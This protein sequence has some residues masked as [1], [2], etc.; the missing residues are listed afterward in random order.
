MKKK[1]VLLL[2][3]KYIYFKNNSKILKYQI[4][5][6]IV[7]N[8][9]VANIEKFNKV[10]S[11]FLKK[12]NLNNTI[13][14]DTIKVI[15]NNTWTNADMFVI[16]YILININ[17]RKIEF[18]YDIDF[19]NMNTKNAYLVIYDNYMILNYLDDYKKHSTILVTSNM[20]D[21]LEDFMDYIATKVLKKELF[22]LG[23]G[24]MLQDFFN[25][26]E[27]TYNIHTYIYANNETYFL[28]NT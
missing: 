6:G 20:Y 17:Y 9:K 2:T 10:F 25:V 5:K 22:I 8:G 19:Y 3:D 26:F 27:D 15:I 28:D 1:N 14:G 16:K 23:Y 11:K 21:K 4:D 12:N 18:I 24:T 7:I 13:F